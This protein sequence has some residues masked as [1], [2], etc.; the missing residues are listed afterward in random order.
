M[1]SR[2]Y[3]HDLWNI[4]LSD[5]GLLYEKSGLIILDWDSPK[6]GG[7]HHFQKWWV[8]GLTISEP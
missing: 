2:E 4:R 1:K 8:P 7:T 5:K 3:T 6:F